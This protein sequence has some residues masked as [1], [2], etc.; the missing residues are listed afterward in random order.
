MLLD[1]KTPFCDII[2]INHVRIVQTTLEANSFHIHTERKCDGFFF[3]LTRLVVVG[4]IL[5]GTWPI[6]ST[7][8]HTHTKLHVSSER[9]AVTKPLLPA[10][11]SIT[12]AAPLFHLSFEAYYLARRA[13]PRV[14]TNANP[15]RRPWCAQTRMLVDFVSIRLLP[16]D[17][18]TETH[19]H[20]TRRPCAYHAIRIF[21][22]I[23]CTA[24]PVPSNP[25]CL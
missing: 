14:S 23:L 20:G 12:W 9:C 18:F 19:N 1:S 15:T 21:L 7:H 17:R 8:T 3:S 22:L 10:W 25:E 2:I 16:P 4:K 6:H 5:H 11:I 13:R 24:A